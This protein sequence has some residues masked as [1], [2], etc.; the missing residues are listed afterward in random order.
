MAARTFRVTILNN[1]THVWD[2]DNFGLMAGIWS[3]T[4]I[5]SEHVPRFGFDGEGNPVPGV[6]WFQSDSDGILTGTE[7]FVDYL[8]QGIAGTLHIH[9]NNPFSGHNSF[10]ASGPLQ[11]NYFWGDPG[12]NDAR[13]TLRIERRMGDLREKTEAEVASSRT[14]SKTIKLP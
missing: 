7:G 6:D 11:F 10:T 5:P 13:I 2:R 8:T 14:A 3:G 4:A 12:G 9:W 1:T